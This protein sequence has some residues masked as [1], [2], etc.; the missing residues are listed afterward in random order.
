MPVIQV[1]S[2]SKVCMTS[3]RSSMA[4]KSELYT[5]K[6][7]VPESIVLIA[8][9][10]THSSMAS[11]ALSSDDVESQMT[12]LHDSESRKGLKKASATLGLSLMRLVASTRPLA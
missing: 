1:H 10:T 5:L 3:S 2:L 8:T 7:R 12:W 11:L 4:H 9:L 6:L